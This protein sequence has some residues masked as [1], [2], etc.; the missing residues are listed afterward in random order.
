MFKIIKSNS[1]EY[2]LIS[3]NGVVI[4]KGRA[5]SHVV[6]P[7]ISYT[8]V[9]AAQQKSN[10]AMTQES[11]DGISLRFKGVV[12]YH[13]EKPEIAS[14]HFDFNTSNGLDSIKDLIAEICYGEIR[15]IVSH[16]TM[17][18]C[19]EQRKE[20]LST[21]LRKK[22]SEVEYKNDNNVGWGIAID[23]AQVAQV[24][25]VEDEIREQLEANLR[26]TL[27]KESELSNLKTEEELIF[28]KN[29]SV[30]KQKEE[31]LAQGLKAGEIEKKEIEYRKNKELFDLNIS[32]QTKKKEFEIKKEIE[33]LETAKYIFN[34]D[35]ETKRIEAE[36]KIETMR[37]ELATLKKSLEMNEKD[38]EYQQNKEILELKKE[39][40]IGKT[41]GTLFNNATLTFYDGK[42]ND[43]MKT[44]SPM[45]DLITKNYQKK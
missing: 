29:N 2:L 35:N 24:F 7:G 25:I 4:N 36:L 32:L 18:E 28:A 3:K 11:K 39:K 38:K 15:D 6:M 10:F 40:A 42:G 12:I 19:I 14:L 22:L 26:N 41:I 5:A 20:L 27:R 31:K 13:V 34:L 30:I 9:S 37:L 16:L 23:I 1:N 8:I 45:F 44:L 17:E 33:E 43:F 21:S